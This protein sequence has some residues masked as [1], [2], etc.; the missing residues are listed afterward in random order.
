MKKI[1][2]ENKFHRTSIRISLRLS[3]V[4]ASWTCQ[5]CGNEIEIELEKKSAKELDEWS[6]K[7]HVGDGCAECNAGVKHE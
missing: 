1:I 4:Y 3:D 2:V 6:A 7:N 5:N